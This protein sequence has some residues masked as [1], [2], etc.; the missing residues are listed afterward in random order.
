MEIE[1]KL[2]EDLKKNSRS[3]WALEGDENSAFFHGLI[4]KHQRSQRINGIKEN[5]FW[6]SDLVEIKERVFKHF[7]GRFTEPIKSRPKFISS[8]FLKLPPYAIEYLEEPFSLAEVKS[9]IWACGLDRAP[10]LDGFSFAFLKQ[11]WETI[12]GD[13]YLAVKHF[14]ASG[15]IEKGCN[16][17][18]ITLVPKVQDPITINDFRPISLIGCL[19][20]TIAKIL[21]ERLKKVVHLVVSPTQ[22]AFL[23]NRHILDGP[24]IL[25]EVI[26]WLK[27]NKKKAFT[28]KADFEKAFDSLSWEFLDSIM[29]QME[30]GAKWRLWI[31]GCLSSTRVSVLV[32]GSATK[33]FGMERGVRQGDPL[34]PFLFNIAAE[35]LHITM[36]EA[37]EKGIFKGLQLP[38]HG[39][40]I[41]HLQ[42]ADD[43]IF[44]GSWSSENIKN[45]IRILRCFELPSGLKINMSKSRLFGFGVQ[46]YELEMVARSFNFLIG[47]LPF[48]YLGLPVGASMT[49]V[50]LWKPII[51]NFQVKLSR[52]KA[53][54]LSFGG[55]LTLCK[56][57]LSSLGSFYFSIYKAPIKVIN[58]LER[59]RMRFFWGGCLESKKMAWIAWDKILAAKEK[60]GLGVGSLKAQN[61]ALLGKWWWHFRKPPDSIW[62]LVIKAIHGADGGISRPATTKR[63][64]GC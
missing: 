47:L 43:V 48:T 26:C 5:G 57:V 34:S 61:L 40:I 1:A 11:H 46:N 49:R 37:E 22:T 50:S 13:F 36:K 28:F 24:L 14:E 63:R 58:S 38:N 44:M 54:T 23:K 9:A 20:K 35:G 42:Y 30:F 41:S 29:Q 32:N 6:I 7:A 3:K 53:S 19:Y 31:H 17:S 2:I 12:G 33:E 51:D 56:A 60:G 16:S 45:L 15:H 4:N 62:A 27:K 52:W 55:R 25:N 8:K 21:V 10:G 59:I 39:P 64:S 18:F